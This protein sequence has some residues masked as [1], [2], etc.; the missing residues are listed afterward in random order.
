MEKTNFLF[1][2]PG[3]I[4]RP[5]L[6]D[7]FDRFKMLSKN[8]SGVIL[9]WTCQN[10]FSYFKIEEFIFN[11]LVLKDRVRFLHKPKLALFLFK[12]ACFYHRNHKKFD[13]IIAFDPMFT[14]V[15]GVFLKFLFRAKLIIEINS[16]DPFKAVSLEEKNVGRRGV[17]LFLYRILITFSLTFADSIKLLAK[18]QMV[19]LAKRFRKRRI[20]CF[21]DFVPTHYFVNGTKLSEKYVF[22]LGFP[23]HRKGVDILIRAFN[24]IS[25]KYPD[26][27]LKLMGHQLRSKESEAMTE[28]NRKIQFLPPVFYDDIREMFL[29]CY[30]FVLPSREEGMG[31]VLLEAMASGKPVI[32]SNIGGIPE[33]IEDQKNGF[34]FQTEDENDLAAKL[35][36]LLG[37][38][39]LTKDMGTY[40]RNLVQEKFS[41]EKYC[42]YFDRMIKQ[43]LGNKL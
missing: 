24:R 40:G 28:G 36:V 32:G 39:Q 19:S 13:V 20:F 11:G 21:H 14:G 10:D 16:S 33:I 4:Y 41:S 43:T 34:L 2:H 38:A 25:P 8:F 29:N 27:V 23:F 17:A 37:N 42:E 30:C 6:P 18:G 26:F 5:D 22:F 9:T 31:K 15:I 1:L 35:D 3:P 7:Y 12:K